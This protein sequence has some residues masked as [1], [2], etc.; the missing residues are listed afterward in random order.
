MRAA[1]AAGEAGVVGGAEN[2]FQARDEEAAGGDAEFAGDVAE[3]FA[4]GVEVD[5][6]AEFCEVGGGEGEGVGGMTR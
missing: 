6:G 1:P 3:R 5:G 2:F 4:G